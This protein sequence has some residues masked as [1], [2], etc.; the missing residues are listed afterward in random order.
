M[1]RHR[2]TLA[3]LVALLSVSTLLLAGC[4]GGST[5]APNDVAVVDGTKITRGTLDDLLVQTK[6]SYKGQSRTFPQADRLF[7][8]SRRLL[9][10]P[11][12]PAN[13][14]GFAAASITQSQ[15][16]RPAKSLADLRSP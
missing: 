13:T 16:G 12:W 5:I 15:A 7:S 9:P 1:T 10:L 3:T 14:L 4:G 2:L 8:K 6:A 11:E